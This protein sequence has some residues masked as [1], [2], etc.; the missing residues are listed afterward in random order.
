MII[1]VHSKRE[2]TKY[3][4]LKPGV[5]RRWRSYHQEAVIFICVRHDVNESL[6]RLV[7]ESGCDHDLLKEKTI[8]EDDVGAKHTLEN[9]K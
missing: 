8:N 6:K 3:S 9:K 1:E 4:S 2:R 7:A 5:V